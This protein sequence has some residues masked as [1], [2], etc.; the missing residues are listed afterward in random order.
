MLQ[1][2]VAGAMAQKPGLGCTEPTHYAPHI[3]TDALLAVNNRTHVHSCYTQVQW[4]RSLDSVPEDLPTI[5]LAH[6]YMDALPVHQFQKTERG[7]RERLVDVAT[8]D[9]PLHLR[10]VLSPGPTPASHLLVDRRLRH[11]PADQRECSR[12]LEV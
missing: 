4:H 2:H 3:Y 5:Y 7:W 1:P 11:L 12:M 10:L 6:E 9:S 8:D